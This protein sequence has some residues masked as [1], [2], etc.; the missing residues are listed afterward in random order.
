MKLPHSGT[1]C[2]GGYRIFPGNRR[3]KLFPNSVE[4]LL[5]LSVN[6][7]VPI[8]AMLLSVFKRE[9]FHG[10]RKSSWI[11]TVWYEALFP[12]PFGNS[13]SKN[14][15]SVGYLASISLCIISRSLS[16]ST[17]SE[18]NMTV[19]NLQSTYSSLISCRWPADTTDPWLRP[20]VTGVSS[21]GKSRLAGRSSLRCR[22]TL[23]KVFWVN[24]LTTVA[25]AWTSQSS[26]T[27]LRS[28]SL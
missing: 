6:R 15:N 2:S 1:M 20:K 28:N 4:D 18:Y 10:F 21:P 27:S 13:T 25:Y 12:F 23:E 26:R 22:M 14:S 16:N 24:T 3:E 8:G 7:I 5:V 9:D 19:L 11:V 17:A